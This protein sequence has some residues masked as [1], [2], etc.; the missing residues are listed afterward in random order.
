ME[1]AVVDK[2]T[3]EILLETTEVL[4][5]AVRDLTWYR[6]EKDLEGVLRDIRA[7]LQALQGI[8]DGVIVA[9]ELTTKRL[10]SQRTRA[11]TRAS[12]KFREK[13]WAKN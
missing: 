13:L 11:Q 1:P 5:R 12:K 8:T 6:D 9:P 4:D 3:H 2:T 7:S 10:Q